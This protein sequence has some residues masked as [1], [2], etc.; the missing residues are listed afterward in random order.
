MLAFS[1]FFYTVKGI[2][3]MEVLKK[4][5]KLMIIVNAIRNDKEGDPRRG[6]K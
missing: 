6:S 2:G 3:Y 1:F 4:L 5:V